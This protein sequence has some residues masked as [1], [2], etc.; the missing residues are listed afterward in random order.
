[1]VESFGSSG[2][3][4]SVEDVGCPSLWAGGSCRFVA[5]EAY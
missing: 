2:L 4:V 5:L 1:M 3:G